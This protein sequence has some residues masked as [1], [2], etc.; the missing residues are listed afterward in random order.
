ML[1]GCLAAG[2]CAAAG[3]QGQEADRIALPPDSETFGSPSGR[4]RFQL[5][6]APS[7]NPRRSTGRLVRRDDGGTQ[8]ERELP[9]A[10]RPRFVVVD[11]TG[12]VA[13]FDEW[14][15]VRS[16]RAISVLDAD[17]RELARYGFDDVAKL[18][19]ATELTITR[20]AHHGW[21]MASRPVQD[22]SGRV[23]VESGGRV[24]V[25]DMASGRLSVQPGGA[26]TVPPAR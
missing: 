21:W 2:A 6:A 15:N 16:R 7:W 1:A 3:R 24:I 20:L 17:G 9:H 10:F 26:P 23:R 18:L 12:H 22:A 8:W 19:G 25:L 13:L 11:D 5:T 4:F 14:L